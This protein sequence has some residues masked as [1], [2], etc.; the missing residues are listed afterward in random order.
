MTEMENF[1]QQALRRR[2]IKSGG[3][4]KEA[5]RNANPALY[6][7]ARGRYHYFECLQLILRKQIAAL[8]NLW[9]LPQEFEVVCRDIWALHLTLLPDPPSA[10][11]YYFALE[12]RDGDSHEHSRDTTGV[13]DKKNVEES[14][15][16]EDESHPEEEEGQE[17]KSRDEE[18]EALLRANSDL[19]DSSDDDGEEEPRRHVRKI[20]GRRRKV[21]ESPASTIAVLIH[22]SV[23]RIGVEVVESDVHVIRSLYTGGQCRANPVASGVTRPGRHALSKRLG[24][25]LSL[26]LTLHHTLAPGLEKRPSGHA[27]DTVAPEVSLMGVAIIVLKMVYG[28]DGRTRTPRDGADVACGLTRAD[29]FLTGLERLE[30]GEQGEELNSRIDVWKGDLS[31]EMMDAYLDFSERVLIG[32]GDGGRDG[33]VLERFF[34]LVPREARQRAGVGDALGEREATSADVAAELRPGEGYRMYRAHDAGG[35]MGKEWAAVVGR[36][37]RWTGVSVE[38]MSAVVETYER[39][40]ARWRPRAADV[41]SAAELAVDLDAH[42][43]AVAVLAAMRR[44]VAVFKRDKHSPPPLVTDHAHSSASSSSGSAS[45]SLQT[46]DDDQHLPATVE[47]QASR[48]SWRLWLK[49]SVKKTQLAALPD[50]APPSH[51]VDDVPSESSLHDDPPADPLQSFTVLV[52]NSL[53]PPP[54][55]PSPFSRHSDDPSVFPKSANRTTLLPRSHS[56]ASVTLKRHILKRL[57]DERHPFSEAEL[58]SIAPLAS[59]S[60][61]PVV[62]LNQPH[63]PFN[64]SA[65]SKTTVISTSCPGLVTWVSRP[66]FEDRYDLFMPEQDGA[67]SRRPIL[68][69]TFAVAALEFSEGIEAMA[70]APSSH[71]VVDIPSETVSISPSSSGRSRSPSHIP[72]PSPLRNE[73]PAPP[74]VSAIQSAPPA[75]PTLTE[76]DSSVKR[77]VRFAEDG[78]DDVIPLGYVLRMKKKREEKAKFLKAEQERRLLEEE[79]MRH[80]EERRRRD[81]ERADWER[82]RRAWEKE[83]RVIEE[84]RRQRKYAEEVHATRLR[85]ESQ[86]AGGVPA[87]KASESNAFLG[88]NP[89]AG[90]FPVSAPSSTSER[91]KPCIV[92]RQPRP[93][94]NDS[95]PAYIPRREASEPNLPTRLDTNPVPSLPITPS[96][97]SHSPDSL[98]ASERPLSPDSSSPLPGMRPSSMHSSQEVPTPSEDV[99]AAVSTTANRVKRHS[100]A[101][102]ISTSRNN[103]N[104]S[105]LGDRGTSY[106]V[107]T[108]SNHSLNMLPAAPMIHCMQMPM[109]PVPTYAMMDMP[110]L[111]PAPPFMM[112]QYT[113]HLGSPGSPGNGGGSPKGRLGAS[114]PSSSREKLD[115]GNPS[116]E[117]VNVTSGAARSGS[118]ERGYSSDRSNKE[119]KS[120]PSRSASF[121]RPEAPRH[122]S[123]SPAQVPNSASPQGKRHGHMQ[124]SSP[125]GPSSRRTSVN[126]SHSQIQQRPRQT[127][128]DL[129]PSPTHTHSQPVLMSQSSTQNLHSPSPWTGLP[130]QS[131]SLPNANSNG[132]GSRGNKNVPPRHMSYSGVRS[133]GVRQSNMRTDPPRQAKRQTVFS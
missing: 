23:T 115:S 59:R 60:I 1:G 8:I 12:L 37:A 122:T 114:S 71:F 79:R 39:R 107:W 13:K 36:G 90:Y 74:S 2:I 85:R 6:H 15:S 24:Q 98:P 7:G 84:E 17:E 128:H 55:L 104:I 22:T 106:P 61:T 126:V 119:S 65:P 88:P 20:Q 120:H 45:L 33:Q 25:I 4:K 28:F 82:E 121:P 41:I 14:E 97:R 91:N 70:D 96:P 69:S 76:A 38:A 35:T 19:E 64:V 109:M 123:S 42:P 5:G 125:S 52:Q 101:A 95:A 56:L 46:P 30:K 32:D 10:E 62:P 66:C 44:F 27:Y 81:A 11:P 47:R 111:P 117:R 127:S 130:T 63:H 103:S 124:H 50:W 68:G 100:F 89:G 34:P 131:G 132:N 57:Q 108:G 49:G 112:Q 99:Q 9:A 31:G 21:Y 129:R 80:E 48:R 75:V 77:G 73:H 86:R 43:V 110:L 87:L 67:I 105:L 92:H 40:L 78:K 93:A 94:Y 58:H 51:D 83:K 102:S 18:L 29:E 116:R 53:L 113:R 133:E 72:A 26:P 54:S 118:V 16:E 3:K